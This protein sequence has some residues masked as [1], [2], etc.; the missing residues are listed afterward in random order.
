MVL[1]EIIALKDG[2]Y[3]QTPYKK[4]D[5]LEV[6][7]DIA[8]QLVAKGLAKLPAAPKKRVAADDAPPVTVKKGDA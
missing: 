5:R 8:Q 6:F 2:V 7:G 1:T 3:F 4:G